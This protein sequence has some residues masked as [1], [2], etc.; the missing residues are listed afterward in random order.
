VS[1]DDFENPLVSRYASRAMLK[2]FSQEA[3]YGTWRELWIALADEQRK[4]GLD[5]TAEQID[6]LRRAERPI[7]FARVAEIERE[8]RHDVMAHVLAWGEQCPEAAGILHLGA[9]SCYVTDNGDLIQIKRALEQIFG[10]LLDAIEALAGFAQRH[11]ATPALGF[12]HFQPAQPVTVGKRACLWIQDLLLDAVELERRLADLPFLGA[13]GTTGTQA[14]FLQLFGG[15]QGKVVSLDAALSR[16]F[17]FTRLLPI[18]GQTY[19]RKIDSQVL[20]VLSGIAQSASKMATDIRLLQHLGELE[21][22]FGSGQVG[23]SAMPYKRNPVQCERI[24]ALGRY[25]MT[26]TQNTAFTAATQWLERSLDDSANRRIALPQA[27]L[28]TDGLLRSVVAVAKGLRVLEHATAQHLATE[29]PFMATESILMASVE[30]GAN[31]QEAHEVIRQLSHEAKAQVR[32]GGENR[33]LAMIAEDARLPLGADDMKDLIKPEAF[34]G[35]SV[36]QT[37]QFLEFHVMGF[38]QNYAGRAS[39]AEAPEV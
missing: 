17:G 39:A 21:E 27:F 19:T 32:A 20:D 37:R 10:L 35:R 22:P 30:K 3:K 38:L 1:A 5:I 33:L 28:A 34:I 9:T 36:E 26:L 13:K 11:A 15:N 31:R 14:S 23:S 2:I 7:P 29:L 16:R 24:C 25:V 8:T 12:T 4:L 6:A 18:S